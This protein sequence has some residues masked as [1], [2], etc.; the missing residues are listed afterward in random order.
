M[1]ENIKNNNIFYKIKSLILNNLRLLIISISILFILI[2]LFQIYSYYQLQKIKKHS[3]EFFSNIEN[4]E[5]IL[6][7]FDNIKNNDNFFSILSSLDLI[8]RYNENNDF[9]NSYIL[10]KELIEK[11]N[12]NSLYISSISSH[13][14]YTFIDASYKNNTSSYLED[15]SYFIGN[16]DDDLQNFFSIKKEL[17][18]LLLIL[19]IDINK[20][21]YKN[22]KNALDLYN[23]IINSDIISSSVKE[24]VKKI[25]EFQ[26]YQ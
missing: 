21:I 5:I 15:I 3:T 20:T 8:K 11:K 12:L 16:I 13:A 23:E 2:I 7:N 26:Y 18:Y 25:H 9:S 10:Y 14:S 4:N 1:N 6:E 19:E 24:R 22:S 17:E